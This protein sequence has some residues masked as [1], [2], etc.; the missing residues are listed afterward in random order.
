MRSAITLGINL[1]NN[2]SKTPNVSK[3]ARYRVW[4]CLFSFEHMLGM[5]TG[6]VIYTLDGGYAT[7]LPLPY[8]EEQ[9]QQD[10]EAVEVLNNPT[11]R[12]ERIN[13]VMA[14]SWIRQPSSKD[15]M[16]KRRPR[17][18]PTW[19]KS[20][21]TSFGLC[22]LYLCDLTVITQEI[23]NRVYST[24]CVML[25]WSEIESQ[26]AEMRSRL[27]CWQ[28]SLPKALDFTQKVA[29]EGADQLRCKL[30]L[31]FHYY[32]ARITLGRPSLCRRDARR[33]HP[34]QTFSHTMAVI[35]LES[36]SHMLDMVPDEPNV[37]QLYQVCP[38]WCV[39]HYLMQAAT[40]ILLELSFGV[41][42]V[43]EQ[44]EKLVKLAKNSIRW[45][46]AMSERSIGSRRAWQ[47]CDS[48][49][50]KIASAMNYST[51]DIPSQPHHRDRSTAD[52][53]PYVPAES[54]QTVPSSGRDYFSLQPEDMG[55]FG[56][57]SATHPASETNAYTSYFNLPTPDLMWSLP[58]PGDMTEEDSYFPYDPLSQEF[59]RSF[60]PS[61]E[62]ESKEQN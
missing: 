30:A 4:W 16:H 61:S 52:T 35:T 1:K 59:I 55:L 32:S 23:V 14:S 3:E 45:F 34:P 37:L 27:D 42:H 21:P 60:F 31:A 12:D 57:H 53:T 33:L 25:P 43:P 15:D 9:L 19:V 36:A 5:M 22:Y 38:W 26:L 29:D 50:R 54:G 24:H 18:E 10:S 39:L 44:E 2:S 58:A 11:M 62:D 41:I 51:D 8:D 28:S 49:F 40:V 17:E 48:S 6:R 13:N 47:L 46:H 20:L 56:S 7:P